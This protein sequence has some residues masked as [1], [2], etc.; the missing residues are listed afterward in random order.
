MKLGTRGI[1]FDVRAFLWSVWGPD[2]GT[3]ALQIYYTMYVTRFCS[4]DHVL[5]LL[6]LNLE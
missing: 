4:F 1:E 3:T 6:Y 5:G 2:T